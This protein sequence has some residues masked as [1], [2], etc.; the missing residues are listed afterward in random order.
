MRAKPNEDGDEKRLED[1]CLRGPL[2]NQ[3]PQDGS[4]EEQASVWPLSC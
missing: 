3:R 1:L 4:M 2:L